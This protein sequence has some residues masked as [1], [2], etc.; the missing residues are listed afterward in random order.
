MY[1]AFLKARREAGE[2][3]DENLIVDELCGKAE[4][5]E[6]WVLEETLRQ[7]YRK[8]R[9][10]LEERFLKEEYGLA[11]EESSN[12][13]KGRMLALVHL[14]FKEHDRM[15]KKEEVGKI[16]DV[17]MKEAESGSIQGLSEGFSEQ[18]C[19]SK[20]QKYR[21]QME[22]KILKAEHPE[23]VLDPDTVQE[24]RIL[25]R[26]Q[27]KRQKIEEMVREAMRGMQDEN[28]YFIAG[29]TE[30]GAP[31]GTTWEEMGL[32]PW[33]DLDE[34][35]LR[36]WEKGSARQEDWEE[37]ARYVTPRRPGP[38]INWVE[39]RCFDET[40][41]GLC[42]NLTEAEAALFTSLRMELGI[43]EADQRRSPEDFRD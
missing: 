21:D 18:T 20:Y 15:P 36:F 32:E 38:D 27:K 16:L 40:P 23:R 13:L 14:F 26:R 22:Q 34:E 11:E 29:Y 4:K 17:L 10:S 9:G 37:N 33:Q 12:T 25:K 7:E 8:R 5:E 39:K 1:Q 24:R 43:P 31:F 35:D 6:I 3:P 19:R 41:W 2:L 28:F 42:Y 30:G